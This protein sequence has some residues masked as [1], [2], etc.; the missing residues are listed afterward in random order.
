MSSEPSSRATTMP[1][2][3][4]NVLS[5]P[6]HCMPSVVA[7]PSKPWMSTTSYAAAREGEARSEGVPDTVT[8]VPRPPAASVA[9]ASAIAPVTLLADAPASNERTR[10]GLDVAIR[11]ALTRIFTCDEPVAAVAYDWPMR[12]TSPGVAPWHTPLMQMFDGQVLPHAPQLTP[13]SDTEM[14][15]PP[16]ATSGASHVSGVTTGVSGG[17]IVGI[18]S[19]GASM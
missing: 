17:T 8:F 12:T 3:S 11:S 19:T 18:T 10:T 9:V 2:F 7:S 6:F 14:H 13:S 15:S 4:V 16:Q 1:P 5:E